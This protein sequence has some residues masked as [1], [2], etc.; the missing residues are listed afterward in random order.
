MNSSTLKDGIRT[1][2]ILECLIVIL[3]V[4][5]YGMEGLASIACVVIDDPFCETLE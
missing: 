1:W 4:G 3:I 2:F 5:R